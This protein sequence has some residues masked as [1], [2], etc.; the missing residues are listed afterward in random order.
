MSDEYEEERYYEEIEITDSTTPPPYYC[1]L[2]EKEIDK[3]DCGLKCE[4]Y[5]PTNGKSGKCMYKRV[6]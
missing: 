3:N 6:N 5:E 1:T 2:F 4:G